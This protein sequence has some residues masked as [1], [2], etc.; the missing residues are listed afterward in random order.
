MYYSITNNFIGYSHPYRNT[1]Y[2]H[3][4]DNKKNY[5][6]NLKN[7]GP[8]W[9]YANRNI[10]YNRNSLGH[11]EKEFAELNVDNYA[12]CVGCS[13]TEGIALEVE[14]RYSN[15]LRNDLNID[16]YN[17]GIG[18]TGNDVIFYNLVTWLHTFTQR[19]KFVVIQ[20]TDIHRFLIEK[21]KDLRPRKYS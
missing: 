7:L 2:Y 12:L 8:N 3:G 17:M 13:I 18:G 1:Q 19:P 11:R 9:Y 20:W 14:N 6:I 16:V 10:T 5:E 21:S 15:F 4:K